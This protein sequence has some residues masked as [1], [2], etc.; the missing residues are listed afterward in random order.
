MSGGALRVAEIS[1]AAI[2]H[3]VRHFRE[4]TGREV[5]TV[6]K[7]NAYGHGLQIC[8]R[9]ALAA[10]AARLAVAGLD[11]ALALRA[12]EPTAPILCWLHGTRTDFV[13]ALA[14]DI[15][16]GMSRPQELEALLAAARSAGHRATV[17]LKVDTGLSRNGGA[18]AEWAEL[19]AL[20]ARGE[21]EGLLSVAGIFSHLANAGEPEDLAQAARFEEAVALLR[22]SGIDPPIRHLAA[23]AAALSRPGLRYDAV[24]VGVGTFGLS[25]F[26]DRSSAE[27]GLVPA[28]TLRSELAALREVPAGAGVS[29]GFAHVASRET[30]LGLVPLGYADGIPRGVNARGASVQIAGELCPIVGRISMDQVV[31]DLSSVASRVRAGDRV[32]FFGDPARGAPAVESWA[33]A[34]DT[35]NYEIVAGIGHRVARVPVET[36]ERAHAEDA[37]EG[38]GATAARE[39]ALPPTPAGPMDGPWREEI[40]VSD[41]EDMHALGVRLGRRLVAGDLVILTGPLG[42]GKTTLARGIGEGLGVRGP[43]TSPTFVLARTHPSE[44]GG[45]PLVHVDAY[46]LDGAAELADLDL[47]EAHSVV[48]AEWGTGLSAGR[49]TWLE[50]AIERPQGGGAPAHGEEDDLAVEPRRLV[51]SWHGSR[52]ECGLR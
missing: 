50:L 27:L 46:R 34:M 45:P 42:A 17:H 29:Y 39:P 6:L 40:E 44:T 14:A 25:P 38:R 23:T 47:D 22:R 30:T 35:I 1:V 32:V 48:V 21:A 24:R 31:V 19:F 2:Q 16:L 43:I 7:A 49:D 10:G 26:P 8:A 3:N 13:P 9:A 33:D 15:E 4:L 28:M 11:E 41:P 51:A 12:F 18:P 5:I 20:A 37:A 52:P 36:E